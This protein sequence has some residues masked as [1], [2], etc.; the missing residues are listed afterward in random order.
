MKGVVYFDRGSCLVPSDQ[1][2][3]RNKKRFDVLTIPFFSIRKGT[4]QGYRLQCE[5]QQAYHQAKEAARSAKKNGI[6]SIHVR[7]FES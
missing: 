3:R 5:Q 4:H 2:R 1:V 7:F 6:I